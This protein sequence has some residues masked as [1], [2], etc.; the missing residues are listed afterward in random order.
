MP[1]KKET[2]SQEEKIWAAVSYLW[3]FSIVALAAR[4]DNDFIRFHANQGALLFVISLPLCFIP[5]IGWLANIL[6]AIVAIIGILK[7]LQGEKWP[8][9]VMP[10]AAKQFG[11]WVIKTLKL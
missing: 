7:S 10:D 2:V 8:L 4:K 6:I 5:V 3:V 11:D 1:T 9:P